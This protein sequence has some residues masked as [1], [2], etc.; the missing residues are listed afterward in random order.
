MLRMRGAGL[1]APISCDRRRSS[2]R[3][4]AWA[5]TSLPLDCALAPVDATSAGTAAVSSHFVMAQA[6]P[7]FTAIN[8]GRGGQFQ[9]AISGVP[10]WISAELAAAGFPI[11]KRRIRFERLGEI[12][13]LAGRT[14]ERREGRRQL[15]R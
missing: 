7:C 1:V 15:D 3:V 13:S 5:A 12:E 10:E 6:F 8:C 14:A 9:Q 4:V 2:A 11:I